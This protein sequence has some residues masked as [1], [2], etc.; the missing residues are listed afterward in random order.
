MRDIMLIYEGGTEWKPEEFRPY[1]AYVD[2]DGRPK[3]WF[4]DA[5]LFLMYG[6]APSGTTYIDGATN[7]ADWEH[8]LNTTF[9][10]GRCLSALDAE[11]EA[12]GQTLKDPTRSCPVIL[13]VPYPSAKQKAFGDVDGDGQSEDLSTAEGRTRAVRWFLDEALVRWAKLAPKHLKLWGFYWMNE[14]MGPADEGIVKG[15]AALVHERRYGFHWIPWFRAPGATRWREM[16]FDFVIMQPNYAFLP[17]R[18]DLA[19]DDQDR[20]SRTANDARAGGM[21]VEMETPFALLTDPAAR[22]IFRQYINHTVDEIDGTM[23][24]AVRAYYQNTDT[25]ARLSQ[26][27]SPSHRALYDDLYRLHKGTY[28]RQALTLAEGRPCLLQSGGG[29]PAPAPRLTDGLWLT[30]PG[31]EDRLLPLGAG[32]SAATLDLGMPTLV[33]DVRVH[34]AAREDADMPSLVRVSAADAPGGPFRVLGE[35]DSMPAERVGEWLAGFV[36]VHFQPAVARYLRVEIEPPIV[37]QDNRGNAPA[38]G[39]QAVPPAGAPPVASQNDRRNTPAAGEQAVPAAGAP[40]I[41]PQNN[42]RNT[43]ALGEIVVP[44]PVHLLWGAE[45]RLEGD[46]VAAPA[47]AY[48]LT[49]GLPGA[50]AVRWRRGPAGI[51]FGT[52]DAVASQVRVRVL[53][54][55]QAPAPSLRVRT[56]AG[57]PWRQAVLSA[58]DAGR[59]W[60]SL[61]LPPEPL[62][63]LALSLEGAGE[64]AVEEV[65]LLPARNLAHGC[66]YTLKP[67]FTAQ[68]PDDGRKLTDGQLSEL[69]F[70]DGKM[71]GWMSR[72]PTMLVD[73]GV[74]R[75]IDAVRAHVEGGGHGAVNTPTSLSVSVSPDGASWR[76]VGVAKQMGE[77]T[78][79][80]PEGESKVVL[81][82]MLAS[83]PRASARF[84]RLEFTGNTWTMVSEVEALS[85]K[86][87]VA[88]GRSYSLLPP[89]TSEQKYADSGQLTDGAYARGPG[90]FRG[91]VG[92]SEAEPQIVVDLLQARPVRI[93]RAHLCGGGPAGVWFPQQV[94]VELSADGTTWSAPV[95]AAEHPAETGRDGAVGFMTARLPEAPPARYVRLTFV[96]HGWAMVDEV[97]VY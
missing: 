62:E 8:F 38:A 64:V 24:G 25:I 41:V 30:S 12:V 96:R 44:P 29:K 42:S 70:G 11:I 35:S 49:E 65:Q 95:V 1:V 90:G 16:G 71:V 74:E 78:A 77:V 76:R 53:K 13:M 67:G 87:N 33:D 61:D 86:E 54:E 69:G 85:G 63:G 31:K 19:L 22:W 59:A 39:K 97:Q 34:L 79:E 43:L 91:F 20:L 14:G 89:P 57:A 51:T 66:P 47:N 73:L 60:L 27:R 83:F 92:W 18:R 26:G 56:N 10:P 50:G 75:S 23:R 32:R 48:A 93:V 81:G 9:A 37:P 58:Q 2:P 15:T 80:R 94:R 7:R 3:D 72:S 52:A 55:A 5:Y 6:G 84:V 4:Y 46:V 28:T 36:I 17:P 45:Y 88:A 68:Y 21:G 82:W 40:A